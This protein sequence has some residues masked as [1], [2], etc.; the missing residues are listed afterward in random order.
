MGWSR[1]RT[2]SIAC[3][4]CTL[5]AGC[6]LL[7]QSGDRSNGDGG[8]NASSTN[9]N[10]T[11]VCKDF[12]AA[13]DGAGQQCFTS[14]DCP[15]LACPCG[16]QTVNSSSCVNGACAGRD[17]CADACRGA[18]ADYTC[19]D[20]HSGGGDGT[21]GK[22]G[23][24]DN[25][26]AFSMCAEDLSSFADRKFQYDVDCLSAYCCDEAAACAASATCPTYDDCV[27]DCL[28]IMDNQERND[29]IH[30]C[31]DANPGALDTYQP[32]SGCAIDHEC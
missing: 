16:D 5:T 30:A 14:E 31:Q 10:N 26:E 22:P 24:T 1:L 13:D 12:F 18:D 11:G 29:C 4:L 7:P 2:I 8:S 9:D 20:Y 21:S 19:A 25:N 27:Y 23:G 6:G 15:V 17:G 3:V 32:F 28:P